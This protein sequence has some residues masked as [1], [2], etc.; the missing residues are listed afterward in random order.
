MT[1]ITLIP[2]DGIGPEITEAVKA[3]FSAAN[4]PVTWEEENAG[5]T[6]FDAKGELLPATLLASLEKNKVA[7]KGPITTP[8]GKGFKSINVQ[9]RQMYDLYANVRPA[10]TTPGIT[11][12]F[13]NVNLVL[14]R[15]NTEGLYSGLEI[16]D[17]RLQIADSISR[18]TKIGC[19]KIVRA[20]FEYADRHGCKKVTVA[21]KANILKH[22]GAMLLSVSKEIA[23]DYP[24]IQMEDKIID[25]MC[26]QLVM[27]PEQFDVIVTTNLFGDILSDLCAGLVG[28]LG[29]VSGANIGDNMAIFEAVHGSAPD[30]AGKGLA[31]PTALLRSAI[32]M[33]H[34]IDLKDY[35][36]KI[37]TAL[38]ATLAHKEECTGDL[39]GSASTK[40]FTQNIIA[41]L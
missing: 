20:A 1:Q 5:Q 38:D 31:N 8:V 41:K 30:I 36:Y 19:E 33:L 25:N 40:E 32:M 28:G 23:K 3:I 11:S 27:K 29:V 17:E 10:K 13:E 14:F 7:L 12:R 2:G 9:L 24:N 21:H 39:G 15:E 4:V 6:T 37:E 35:A 18:V 26:M 16:F 34:H 22:A